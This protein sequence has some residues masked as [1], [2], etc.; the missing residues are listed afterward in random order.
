M[1][2]ILILT[3]VFAFSVFAN[4]QKIEVDQSFLDDCNKAFQLV[5]EQRDA[6]EKF[7]IER[8]KNEIERQSAQSLIDG[9]NSLITIKDRTIATYADIVKFQQKIIEFQNEIITRLQQAINKPKSGF[10]KF[11]R[12]LKEVSILVSGIL[13][14]R[15]LSF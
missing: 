13:I 12:I 15:G 4:A 10:S 1:K 8:A 9:L 6:L 11:L 2:L 7:K 14:G 3:F 5:I